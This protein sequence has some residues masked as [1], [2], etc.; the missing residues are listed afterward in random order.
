MTIKKYVFIVFFQSSI[1]I[2]NNGDS[3][4]NFLHKYQSV[5]NDLIKLLLIINIILQMNV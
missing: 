4:N 3:F 1:S 2:K 5:F